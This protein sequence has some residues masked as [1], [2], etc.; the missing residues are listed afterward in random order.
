M[1]GNL[2]VMMS[3]DNSPVNNSTL[4]GPP[5]AACKS[6]PIHQ[7]YAAKHGLSGLLK[8]NLVCLDTISNSSLLSIQNTPGS[9]VSGTSCVSP[10]CFVDSYAINRLLSSY[11]IK[12]ILTIGRNCTIKQ[13]K[14]LAKVIDTDVKLASCL[15]LF[16]YPCIVSK[17]FAP[18]FL[19]FF[20]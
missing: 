18:W 4:V 3:G 11:N 2:L 7:V 6:D 16:Y 13:S 15:F 19:L 17:L 10:S 1:K 5:S 12:F 14:A 20:L 9:S 8:S